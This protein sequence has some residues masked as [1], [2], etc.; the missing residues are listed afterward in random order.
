MNIGSNDTQTIVS[1]FRQQAKETPDNIAVVYKDKQYTYAEVDNISDH[2]AGYV[3][4][5]G[6]G[7]ED[8]VSILIAHGYEVT[9]HTEVASEVEREVDGIEKWVIIEFN[10]VE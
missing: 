9:A 5:R 6:L 8:V 10:E 7:L 4:S 2:I 3:A 1:L